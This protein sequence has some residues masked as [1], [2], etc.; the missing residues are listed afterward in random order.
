MLNILLGT[1]NSVVD[2][3]QALFS[4]ISWVIRGDSKQITQTQCDQ[5]LGGQ[6]VQR[7]GIT[8][9]RAADSAS[10]GPGGVLGEVTFKLKLEREWVS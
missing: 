10:S 7:T 6:E 3:V 4:W 9:S 8:H 1:E 2:N 5:W